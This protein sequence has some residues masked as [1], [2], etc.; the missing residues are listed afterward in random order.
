MVQ[1][2]Q[3]IYSSKI[4]QKILRTDQWNLS[5]LVSDSW[6]VLDIG[7]GPKPPVLMYVNPSSYVGIDAYQFSIDRLL[8]EPSFLALKNKKAICSEIQNLDFEVN[9]FDAV[10]LVDVIE[11]LDKV[12]GAELLR[13]AIGWARS[14]VYVSTPNG[15]LEQ[16]PYD[17]NNYQVHLSGWDKKDFVDLGFNRIRGGGGPKFMRRTEMDPLQWSHTDAGSIRFRPK[18]LWSVLS[19]VCQSLYFWIPSKSF[20]LY[21]V[22]EKPVTK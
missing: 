1:L 6:S 15:F 2:L 21:A 12:E 20:Q 10:L 16:K 13:K 5:N 8:V 18:I 4:I 17:S 9:Q 19:A 14:A 11:H 7:C 3:G 22:Y